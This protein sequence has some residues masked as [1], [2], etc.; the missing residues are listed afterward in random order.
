MPRN[1]IVRKSVAGTRSIDV[2]IPNSAWNKVVGDRVGGQYELHKILIVRCANERNLIRT[3]T[4]WQTVC[5]R[6]I[7]V[8][9]LLC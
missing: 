7:R 2:H 5:E 6:R 8:Q 9:S 3:D 4:A 1:I